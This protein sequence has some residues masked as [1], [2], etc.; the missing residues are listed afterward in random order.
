MQEI[1]SEI[2]SNDIIRSSPAYMTS[3]HKPPFVIYWLNYILCNKLGQRTNSKCVQNDTEPELSERQ[4]SSPAATICK[5]CIQ[6]K[7]CPRFI[8]ALLSEGEFKT[9]WI[10]LYTRAYIMKLER[11]R[12]Q[13]LANQSQISVGRKLDWANS[14]LYT[15]ATIS[16]PSDSKVIVL[17]IFL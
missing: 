17:V 6:G 12:I 8:F 9:G 7:F 11:G 14:K 1:I 13:D 2:E 4:H 10:E 15:V 16:N 3:W 5:Y